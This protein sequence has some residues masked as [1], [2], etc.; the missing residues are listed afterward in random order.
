[1]S[2]PPKIGSIK[3]LVAAAFAGAL[4]AFSA[5]LFIAD[6]SDQTQKILVM[7]N[8]IRALEA[9]LDQKDQQLKNTNWLS[10]QSRSTTNSNGV[11][12]KLARTANSDL[13][14]SLDENAQYGTAVAI[15]SGQMLK[16]LGTRSIDDPRSFT[17]KV[18]DLLA[19]DASQEKVA[20]VSK[21]IFDMANDRENLPDY[22]LQSLYTKQSD[23]DVKR[24][25]AQVLS[26]RGNNALMEN[27]LSDA[28]TQ[29]KSDDPTARQHALQNLAKTHY[30]NAVSV[31]APMLHDA[32]I[33]VRLDA[34]LA[35]RATGNQSHLALVEKLVNDP[36]PN[37]SSL[38]IDVAGHLRNLSDSART[39]LSSADIAAELPIIPHP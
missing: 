12:A 35:M 33:N 5:Q 2:T 15:D 7:E 3:P 37:I 26:Q 28:R 30:V 36:D 27:H 25:I 11:A 8:R 39:T 1:M 18:S 19:Q 13:S 20:I 29:L 24:V 38:A 10:L 23:P 9:L 6:D 34:L 32:D 22:A 31:I 16:N 14:S 17:E 21:G 4:L